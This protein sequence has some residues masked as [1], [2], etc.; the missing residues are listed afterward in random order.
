M[1]ITTNVFS[2]ENN[3]LAGENKFETSIEIS[4]SWKTSK[5]AI[6]VNSSATSDMLC[7]AVLSSQIDCPILLTNKEKINDNIIQELHRLDT[8][9]V[10]IIGGE[11]SISE[12][13]VKTIHEEHI[14]TDRISGEDRYETSIKIAEKINQSKITDT[15]ILVNGKHSV[16]DAISISPIAGNKNIPVIICKNDNLEIQKKWIKDN[17]IK[18]VYI[19]GGTNVINK[20]IEDYFYNENIE[21]DRISGKDRYKTNAKVLNN[22]YTGSKINKLFYCNGRNI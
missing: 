3:I 2:V 10:Y 17:N 4:K 14:Y 22:F 6:L 16:A 20:E 5:E 7:A 12:K 8:E 15:I 18:N 11:D 21:V 13:I 19:I 9:V 1:L